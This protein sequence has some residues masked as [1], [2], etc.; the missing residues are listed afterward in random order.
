GVVA[1]LIGMLSNYPRA[2]IGP[3]GS[4]VTRYNEFITIEGTP[5]YQAMV[6]RDL[7]TIAGT[8]S[9]ERLLASMAAS[10]R[11]CR[12]HTDNNEGNWAWT[13]P[14]P[15]G[16]EGTHGNQADTEIGYNP[17]R[18]SLSGPPGSPYN[19]ANWAQE[20]NRPADVGLFHEM[21][22]ADDMMNGR[23]PTTEGN[24]TGPMAGTPIADSELR[25]AGLP[26]YDGESYSENSYRGDRG[27]PE[28]TFY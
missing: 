26:P 3:D 22:H 9:G 15:T 19:T 18:T 1:G 4:V 28:R 10:G 21:V 8:P 23:M 2:E 14:P 12:I 16:N 7:N 27:L 13:D 25:A 20:P 24:N 5:E 17:E 6:V 11:Q